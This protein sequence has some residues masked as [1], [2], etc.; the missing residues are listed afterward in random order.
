MMRLRTHRAIQLNFIYLRFNLILGASLRVSKVV[1]ARQ[2]RFVG[3]LPLRCHSL[4]S[5][6]S[7]VLATPRLASS[8]RHCCGAF[9]QG[10]SRRTTSAHDEFGVA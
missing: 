6:D 8:L 3:H 4:Q 10:T 2:P 9:V 7:V 5:S 1:V